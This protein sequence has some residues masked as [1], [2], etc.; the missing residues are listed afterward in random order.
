[1]KTLPES[2]LQIIHKTNNI[3]LATHI[4]PDGDALGSLIGLADTLEGMGK[5]VFRYLEEPVSH[6]YEFLPDTGLMQT[7][8]PALQD[9]ARQAGRDILCISLDLSLIHISEPTRPY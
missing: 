8:I 7:D 6:L 2:L 4:N 5:K 1:M 3:V 9:F